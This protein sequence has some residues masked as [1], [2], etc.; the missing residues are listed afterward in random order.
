MIHGN[1]EEGLY[2]QVIIDDPTNP[3]TS[4]PADGASVIILQR[5]FT[6]AIIVG[7]TTGETGHAGDKGQR[8][9]VGQVGNIFPCK[10]R[11]GL[12]K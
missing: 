2:Q 3:G 5:D 8:I 12:K 6:Q 9:R 7:K 10:K 4:I 11:A 1:F